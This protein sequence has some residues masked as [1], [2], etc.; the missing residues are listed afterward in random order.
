ML[1]AAFKLP[2]VFSPD[3]LD[4]TKNQLHPAPSEGSPQGIAHVVSVVITIGHRGSRLVGS[5]GM[6]LSLQ[7]IAFLRE[8]SHGRD[9]RTSACP[10][11][12]MGRLCAAVPALLPGI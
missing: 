3:L 6:I 8:F 1:L 7:V 9:I 11:Q 2:V 4:V 10:P 5:F 12:R